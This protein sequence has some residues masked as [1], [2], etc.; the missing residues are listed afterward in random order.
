MQGYNELRAMS[1]L[2]LASIFCISTSTAFVVR[3]SCPSSLLFLDGKSV[4]AALTGNKLGMAKRGYDTYFDEEE[5]KQQPQVQVESTPTTTTTMEANNGDDIQADTSD[6]IQEDNG[7]EIQREDTAPNNNNNM[8]RHGY[9]L[10][11][12]AGPILPSCP[13]TEFQIHKVLAVRKRYQRSQHYEKADHLLQGLIQAGVFVHDKRKE[14]RADGLKSFGQ[15]AASKYSRRGAN[16]EDVSE[17]T[18]QEISAMVEARSRAKKQRDFVQCDELEAKLT[19]RFKVQLDDKRREWSFVAPLGS[20]TAYVPSPLAWSG[21][22]THT[23]DAET[24]DYIQQQLLDRTTARTSREYSKADDIR[25]QLLESHAVVIDDRTM[26][27]KVV[28]DWNDDSD[29]FVNEAQASQRSAFA[30]EEQTQ[31]RRIAIVENGIPTKK[32]EIKDVDEDD[33]LDK[34]FKS[35]F[36]SGEKKHA[37]KAEDLPL[38]LAAAATDDTNDNNLQA[39]IDE[40]NDAAD[41]A[42]LSTLTVVALKEKLR[43][44]GLPVSG[45]KAELV[46]RLLSSS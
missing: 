16:L 32:G 11:A 31:Q 43:T 23:M 44:K 18:L 25:D 22:P 8:P 10:A 30:R 2:L 5:A 36:D 26:E 6:E 42:L 12:D 3:P 29:P 38:P 40:E 28:T 1:I 27:W 20:T 7:D 13:L 37:P 19:H 34:E 17:E 35:I 21:D 15:S 46:D 41:E 9:K 45:R 14:W 33:S 24:R 4:V 39:N